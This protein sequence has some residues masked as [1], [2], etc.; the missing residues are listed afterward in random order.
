[1]TTLARE[2]NKKPKRK[3]FQA[4]ILTRIME[5]IRIKRGPLTPP[6]ELE[7]RHVFILPSKFGLGFGF[8]LVFMVLGGLNFNNNMALMLVF[9]LGTITQMTTLLAY[10][11]LAGLN[12]DSINVEPVF[13]GESARFRVFI[14]NKNERQ[15]FAVQAGFKDAL[16]CQDLELNSSTAMLLPFSTET[17]GWLDMPAFRIETRFPLG[18]FKAWSWIFP[19]TRCLVYPSPASNPPALPKTGK[20]DAGLASK[21][22]GDQVHGLRKYQAGDSM[23]RIAWR[24]SARHDEFYSLEMET[25]KEDACELDFDLLL[26]SD[27][28]R[29]LSILTAWVIIADRKQMTYSLQLPNQSIPAG[30]GADQRNICLE[31]LALFK[32]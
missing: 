28:E 20:G 24:A 14:T 11:N 23:Q 16:D 7:Y 4:A 12:V 25:P 29:R 13:R 10:R 1:M 6:F 5:R 19:Q 31:Q 22:E 18:M 8:M 30:H 17:R 27:V 21:G 2:L 32:Q 3:T 26:G 9:L 15:R